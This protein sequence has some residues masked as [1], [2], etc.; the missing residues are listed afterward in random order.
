MIVQSIYPLQIGGAEVYANQLSLRLADLGHKLSICT[1]NSS[2]FRFNRIKIRKNLTIYPFPYIFLKFFSFIFNIFCFLIQSLR[3][4]SK[5]KR[6]DLIHAHTAFYPAITGF[7]ISKLFNVPLIVTCHGSEIKFDR[8]NSAIRLIQDYILK[9]C[10]HVVVVSDEL[11]R[12]LLRDLKTLSISNIPGGVD[13]D[14]FKLPIREIKPQ[15]YISLLFVGNLREVKNPRIVL[16]ALHELK[17]TK[18]NLKLNMIGNGNLYE[19]LLEFCQISQLPNVNLLRSIKHEKL[20]DYYKNSDIFLMPSLSEGTPLALIEAMAS[21]KPII[22]S[23]VGGIVDL[24]ED[25]YNGVLI[26]PQ[27]LTQLTEKIQY[28]IANSEFAMT[29]GTNARNTVSSRSWEN[30]TREYLKIYQL[31]IRSGTK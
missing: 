24:I 17:D 11:K 28:L 12:M 26:N 13:K 21:A 4:I 16:E 20:R 9:R 19:G 30:I 6:I 14:Y 1:P 27:D 10:H 2:D 23:N 25:G 8:N 5:S 18:L 3:I 29:I 7:I 31:A 22:A 15:D